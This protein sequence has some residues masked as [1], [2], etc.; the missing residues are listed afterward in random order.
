VHAYRGV[1]IRYLRRGKSFSCLSDE[2]AEGN[3]FE[4]VVLEEVALGDM[5]G[6]RLNALMFPS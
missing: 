3:Y 5:Y 2:V 4:D 6:C 1:V